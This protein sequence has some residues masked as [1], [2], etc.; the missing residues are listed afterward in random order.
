MVGR[1]S[2]KNRSY[3]LFAICIIVPKCVTGSSEQ[4]PLSSIILLRKKSVARSAVLPLRKK[5]R[6]A[7]L[8]VC[9]RTP[10]ASLSLPTFCD[11]YHRLEMCHRHI[12]G[13][14]IFVCIQFRGTFL[15]EKSSPNP[16][17]RSFCLRDFALCGGRPKAPPFRQNKLHSLRLFCFAKNQSTVPLFFLSAKSLA[18]LS[19]SLINA[20]WALSCR[21]QLFAVIVYF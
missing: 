8:L 17:K 19:C 18:R 14:K 1:W 7:Q 5:S 20:L 10:G 6:S 16:F 15:R 2:F 12:W 21:Y 13:G 4:A 3:R 11:M 9:K